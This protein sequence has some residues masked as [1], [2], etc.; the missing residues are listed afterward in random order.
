[1]V[2]RFYF[3]SDATIREFNSFSQAFHLG[4]FHREKTAEVEV[5]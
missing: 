3:Q 1:M 2:C 5:S 4:D